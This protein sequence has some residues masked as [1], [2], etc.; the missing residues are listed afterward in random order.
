MG[1][2][3]ATPLWSLGLPTPMLPLLL[4]WTTTGVSQVIVAPHP[5]HSSLP[6]DFFGRG[7]GTIALQKKQRILGKEGTKKAMTSPPSN[8][9]VHAPCHREALK[10][11]KLTRRMQLQPW[12]I[13]CYQ[14]ARFMS[15]SPTDPDLFLSFFT[16]IPTITKLI[17]ATLQ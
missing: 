3:E 7:H 16:E 8:A 12:T 2:V 10:T 17:F 5:L 1:G 4:S 15:T 9:L 11:P 13:S 6:S 14:K